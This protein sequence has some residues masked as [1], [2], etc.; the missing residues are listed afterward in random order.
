[1]FP[2]FCAGILPVS[3]ID[4]GKTASANSRSTITAATSVTVHILLFEQ[5]H[6]PSIYW[7]FQTSLR[8][9]FSPPDRNHLKISKHNQVGDKNQT[10]DVKSK[11]SDKYRW[12]AVAEDQIS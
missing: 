11:R 7:Q 10:P 1:M 3:V 2:G 9:P 6:S 4:N 12:L 5:L 8:R